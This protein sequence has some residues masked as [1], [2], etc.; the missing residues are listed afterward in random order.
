MTIYHILWISIIICC[1]IEVNFSVIKFNRLKIQTRTIVFAF[2]YLFILLLGIWRQE[3]LGVDVYN[4]RSRFFQYANMSFMDVLKFPDFEKGYIFINKII[5]LFSKDF[6]V[7]KAVLY[8][9]T[10]TL[11]SYVIYKSSKYI[12]VSYLFY[13]GFGFLGFNFCI[14]R[15]ALA[16][17]LCF[18][19]Y[20]FIK[21]K[22]WLPFVL[23]VI[24][25]TTIHQTAICYLLLYPIVHGV[26][27]DKFGIKKILLIFFAITIGN[28]FL[29]FFFRFSDNDYSGAV[30]SG[31]GYNMLFLYACLII[32]IGFLL[33]HL[34]EHDLEDEYNALF[35]VV[36]FQVDAIFFSLIS[37]IVNYFNIMFSIVVPNLIFRYKKKNWLLIIFI[38]ICSIVYYTSLSAR[39]GT[40]IVPYLS[41]FDK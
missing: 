20:R 11:F 8:F 2:L 22:K 21:E 27:K 24:I 15:Q 40:Y 7:F 1:F 38:L 35:A 14:L 18:W 29:P 4:Y 9:M 28:I 12:S 31:T 6:W 33:K 30:V 32:L 3:F 36:Y 5:Q 19:S 10:F 41:I 26:Y 16:V 23:T 13:I 39:G 25:A 17:S 37:R 34:N